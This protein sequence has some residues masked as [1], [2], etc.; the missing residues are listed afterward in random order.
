MT[1]VVA[2]VDDPKKALLLI[3]TSN[4]WSQSQDQEC[5]AQTPVFFASNR[6]SQGF[7]PILWQGLTRILQALHQKPES[8]SIEHSDFLSPELLSYIETS[9][10]MF[11]VGNAREEVSKS[12]KVLQAHTQLQMQQQAGMLKQQL[13]QASGEAQSLRAQLASQR[14][15]SKPSMPGLLHVQACL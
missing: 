14:T 5:N 6:A 3:V 11:S 12:A 10:A 13:T 8:L 4:C 15:A 2:D 1:G 9:C 7:S